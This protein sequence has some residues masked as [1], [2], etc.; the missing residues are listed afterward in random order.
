[1]L[2]ISASVRIPDIRCLVDFARMYLMACLLR[3]S[4]YTKERQV[5]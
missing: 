2:M 1:M 5:R 3:R 4:P